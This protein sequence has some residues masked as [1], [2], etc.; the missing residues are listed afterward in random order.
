MSS[1]VDPSFC[2][3]LL[4]SHKIQSSIDGCTM[5]QLF[6]LIWERFVHRIRVTQ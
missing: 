1:H 5:R 3:W 4:P 6:L 2:Q